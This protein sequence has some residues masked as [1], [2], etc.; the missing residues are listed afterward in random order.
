MPK[1]AAFYRDLAGRCGEHGANATTQVAREQFGLWQLEFEAQA[2]ALEAAELLKDT[3]P[4]VSTT[5]RR[6]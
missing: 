5:G 1:D 4:T 6:R 2:K 3:Q